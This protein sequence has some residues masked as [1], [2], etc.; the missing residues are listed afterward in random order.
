MEAIRAFDST[1]KRARALIKAHVKLRGTGPGKRPRFHS[2]LLRAAL[3]TAVAAMD[4]YFHDKILQ[5]ISR[6]IKRTGPNFPED[7]VSLLSE[8]QN[9]EEVVRAFLK[10]SMEKRPLSH[11]NT[12]AARNLSERT[13]QDPGKIERGL[14]IIGVNNFWDATSNALN[15]TP[16]DLKR[17]ILAYVK[18]QH[19]IVHAGDLWKAKKHRHKVRAITPEFATDCI[20]DIEEFVQTADTVINSQSP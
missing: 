2:E 4:A 5:N 15:T 16:R 11:V 13:Y 17:K 9:K 8:N 20:D 19:S 14:R 7:L 1:V 10:I 18:R 12:K 3:V 6:T